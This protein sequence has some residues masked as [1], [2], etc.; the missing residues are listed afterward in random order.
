MCGRAAQTTQ[1]ADAAAMRLTGL[2]NASTHGSTHGLMDPNSCSHPTTGSSA[3]SQ[4]EYRNEGD[5]TSSS[6]PRDNFNMSPGMEAFVM[7]VGKDK[8][9][10]GGTNTRSLQVGRKRWGLITKAGTTHKPLYQDEKDILKMC[11]ENLCFNARSDTLFGKPTFSKL[12]AQGKSCVVALDGYFEWKTVPKIQSANGKQPY[13]VYRKKQERPHSIDDSN[14]EMETTTL[15][16]AGLWTQVE[17]GVPESP[18]LDSFAILTTEANPQIAWLH[19]RMPVCLWDADLVRQWLTQP[20]EAVL[21]RID[22]AAQHRKGGFGW[23]K[24]TPEMS[25]LKFRGHEA[26]E[27]MKESTQSVSS[28]F[29]SPAGATNE[30]NAKRKLAEFPVNVEESAMPGGFLSSSPSTLNNN[31]AEQHRS[32][33][34]I[35]N[36]EINHKHSSTI[37]PPAVKKVKT[38][39]SAPTFMTSPTTTK[40]SSVANKTSPTKSSPAKKNTT[41]AKSTHKDKNVN[42]LITSFFQKK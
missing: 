19:D 32:V 17:T 29:A 40:A 24:V 8:N 15:I 23:H 3:W 10:D 6:P 35:D 9:I 14:D 28:F 38:I 42:P 27:A 22:D 4:H 33:Y 21:K 20:S 11:F 34:D 5:S 18:L 1:A 16:M 12:A 7:W 36:D 31:I 26:V 25:K 2:I 41:V 39:T 37:S 13:F 30:S